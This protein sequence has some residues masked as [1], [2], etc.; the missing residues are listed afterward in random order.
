[1]NDC[2]SCRFDIVASHPCF[3]GH[4][5]GFPVFP[6]VGQL[7]LLTKAVSLLRG[8]ACTMS[9]ILSVKF[10]RPIAPD[11]VIVVELKSVAENKANFVIS[12][13]EGVVSKGKFVYRVLIP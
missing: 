5:P 1:M 11:T 7:S 6:A 12:C 13:D 9:S 10:M 8:E 2:F 3:E 4:F